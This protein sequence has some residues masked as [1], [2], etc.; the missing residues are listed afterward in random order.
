MATITMWTHRH[1]RCILW[2]EHPTVEVRILS[3]ERVTRTER[4]ASPDDALSVAVRWEDEYPGPRVEPPVPMWA[5]PLSLAT[6]YAS[7][8]GAAHLR[9]RQRP[10]Q[11][12]RRE[13]AADRGAR[14]ETV[15]V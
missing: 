7:R 14:S 12:A 13:R 1:C 5:A 6:R 8:N 15:A 2:I 9:R 10:I 11:D 3:G 4:A